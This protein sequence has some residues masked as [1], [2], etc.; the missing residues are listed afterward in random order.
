MKANKGNVQSNNRT[1]L[2]RI[3]GNENPL[4]DLLCK[5][6]TSN[7]DIFISDVLVANKGK[8]NNEKSLINASILHKR[9]GT[10]TMK[11]NNKGNNSVQH[12]DMS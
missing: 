10:K 5:M 1:L 4:L 2:K 8:A 7:T 6:R 12:V 3:C 9:Q 11:A